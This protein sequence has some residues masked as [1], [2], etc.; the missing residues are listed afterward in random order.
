M[1]F[2]TGYDGEPEERRAEDGTRILCLG[3]NNGLV[4]TLHDDMRPP[5]RTVDKALIERV[6][7]RGSEGEPAD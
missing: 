7:R 6:W 5:G 3:V 1:A 4:K 2:L